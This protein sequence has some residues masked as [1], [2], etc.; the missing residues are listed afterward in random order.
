MSRTLI[1]HEKWVDLFRTESDNPREIRILQTIE[2]GYNSIVYLMA[3]DGHQYAVKMYHERYSGSPACRQERDHM[4]RARKSIPTAVPQVLFCSAHTDNQ[5]Q[6]E[7]LVMDRARG[8]PLSKDVFNDRIFIE[9]VAILQRLHSTHVPIP[10]TWSELER[11]N[12]CRRTILRFLKDDEVIPRMRALNHL[13]ALRDYYIEKQRLFTR[14]KTIIHGDLWWDNI[15][16]DNG[17]V[18]LVDWLDSSEQNYCRDLAQ[19]KIG[20]LNEML[21]PTESQILFEQMMQMYAQELNDDTIMERMRYHLPLLYLEEALYLPFKFFP[22]ELKY[23]DDARSFRKRFLDYYHRS[24]HAF[25]HE[26]SA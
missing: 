5:F 8:V 26:T 4:I 15:L 23:I 24:E 12:T 21:N 20:T 10:P 19:F 16:V 9:L 3:V 1:N 2:L 14:R 11:I 18:T 7:I 17:H 25:Q 6:R 22:W 13:S